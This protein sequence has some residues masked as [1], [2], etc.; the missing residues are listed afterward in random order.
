MSGLA[1]QSIVPSFAKLTLNS[2]PLFRDEL[3]ENIRSN[4]GLF[5][6]A[7]KEDR[8]PLTDKNQMSDVSFDAET[9]EEYNKMDYAMK[10]VSLNLMK[11][12]GNIPPR[13]SD[14][15][16]ENFTNPLSAYAIFEDPVTP[17]GRK[18]LR[19]P[20]MRERC[21]KQ[22][23]IGHFA[24]NLPLPI[25]EASSPQ[26][27]HS[28]PF[29]EINKIIKFPSEMDLSNY[30]LRADS[31]MQT[32]LSY[33][34][35]PLVMMRNSSGAENFSEVSD[36][37]EMPSISKKD[38]VSFLDYESRFEKE[39]EVISELGKGHF[40]LIK[41]CRNRLD[42]LEYAVKITK[43]KWKGERGKLEALQEVFA[44]SALSVCDDN[45]YIVKYFNG[46]IEDSKLYIVV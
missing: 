31:S 44:L 38:S 11:N 21:L 27:D 35:S 5:N 43:H 12:F 9:Q 16:N 15:F 4:Q 19:S 40:G 36:I 17:V 18:D 39:F 45:P 20:N 30:L 22:N 28:N 34:H 46:W 1:T 33:S 7:P 23:K 10:N 8:F 42:G 3:K 2:P 41:K 37:I 14:E 26:N 6:V 24:F 32:P 29:K 25:V 13:P